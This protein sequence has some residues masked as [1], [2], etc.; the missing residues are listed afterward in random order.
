MVDVL[1]SELA[2]VTQLL[3]T[4]AGLPGFDIAATRDAVTRSLA[5]RI[6]TMSI[7]A[8]SAQTL[9][10]A[11]TQAPLGDEQRA[12]L[13]AAVSARAM[14]HIANVRATNLMTG[15]QH[16]SSPNAFLV[17]SDWVIVDDPRASQSVKICTVV[18]RLVLA[19]VTTPSERTIKDVS[20]LLSMRM[21]P[22]NEPE[23]SD[24]YELVQKVKRAF[25]SESQRALSGLTHITNYPTSPADL[26][27]DVFQS[28]Y[29]VEE[30]VL[31]S[32]LGF[33]LRRSSM[34]MRTSNKSLRGSAV[35]I[36][37]GQQAVFMQNMM[38]M[39]QMI[40]QGQSQPQSQGI[41]IQYTKGRQGRANDS[42]SAPLMLGNGTPAL[43]DLG[44]I[45]LGAFGAGQSALQRG[46]HGDL[47]GVAVVSPAAQL[48]LQRGSL[49]EP[50]AAL[51]FG[52][53][54]RGGT[55]PPAARPA[56]LGG[57]SSPDL[58]SD[59]VEALVYLYYC[60]GVHVSCF[61]TRRRLC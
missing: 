14:S 13:A 61:I 22:T 45:S 42:H 7:T 44:G 12:S 23:A 5:A 17:Q 21:W 57:A 18:A 1:V 11:I 50:E 46:S 26:P 41:D 24:S 31:V 28:A 10:S 51:G 40:Q 29:G 33:E 3:Q 16:L 9:T 8:E 49:A 58:G 53:G 36:P 35:Q 37:M 38:Q 59:G 48:A 39:M 30:P 15:M 43:G 55:P 20:T 2:S 34:C 52:V 47:G 27:R 60:C 19:G 4:Q 56:S 6:S 25:K 32:M 54:L